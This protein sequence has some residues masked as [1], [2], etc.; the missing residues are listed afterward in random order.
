MK[1]IHVILINYFLVVFWSFVY[2]IK[3]YLIIA[4]IIVATITYKNSIF[5]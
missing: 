3:T 2:D 1:L 5:S 4:G